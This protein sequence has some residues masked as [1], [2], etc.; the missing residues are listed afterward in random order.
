MN[1]QFHL[2]S[3]TTRKEFILLAKYSKDVDFFSSTIRIV[4]F[5]YR[6]NK[7]SS[8]KKMSFV[9][10]FPSLVVRDVS[11][12]SNSGLLF[13]Q[14]NASA[15]AHHQRTNSTDDNNMMK[16]VVEGDYVCLLENESNHHQDVNAMFY[17]KMFQAIKHQD[18]ADMRCGGGSFNINSQ[19]T[20]VW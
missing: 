11:S 5:E 8:K 7:L 16:P 6:L 20:L 14:K 15:S 13:N 4:A 19:L 17:E 3:L 2:E 12:S 1:K 18:E 9:E 10:V